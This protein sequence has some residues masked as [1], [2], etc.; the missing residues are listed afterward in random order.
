MF[1]VMI[2]WRISLIASRDGDSKS[3]PNSNRARRIL[4]ENIGGLTTAIRS[5]RRSAG[6]GQ[7]R[8]RGATGGKENCLKRVWKQKVETIGEMIRFEARKPL[9]LLARLEGFEPPTLRSEV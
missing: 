7:A 1:S 2:D 4:S 9:N 5:T 8:R 6:C 3:D